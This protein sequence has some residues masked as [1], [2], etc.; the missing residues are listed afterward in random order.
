MN[1][2][3]IITAT[4]GRFEVFD[5]VSSLSKL[6]VLRYFY[7][8][9]PKFILKKYNI[10]S[11]R[12]TSF[13][14]IELFA[15]LIDILVR[16]NLKFQYFDFI[17]SLIFE[18]FVIKDIK[19]K[20]FNI[21]IGH[22]GYC[23]NIFKFLENNKDI[24]KILYVA[25]SHIDEKTKLVGLK[26]N[27]IISNSYYHKFKNEYQI[28]DLIICQS[29]HV[30]DGFKK[31][32]FKN[33]A[34]NVSGVNSDNFFYTDL[35]L[36]NDED[37]NIIFVGSIT[38]RKGIRR[39][40]KLFNQIMIDNKKLF[41]IG[42]KTNEI[43]LKKI[44]TDNIIY[45][46]PKANNALYKY[47]SSADLLFLFSKEEGFS[48]VLG[49]S[50]SCGTP[51][52]ASNKSGAQHFIDKKERGYVFNKFNKKEIINEIYNLFKIRKKIR[53]NKSYLSKEFK[54]KHT[55]ME[56][57]KKLVLIIEKFHQSKM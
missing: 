8:S 24:S 25:S 38:E 13:L 23:E 22:S 18:K 49:Q 14:V 26:Q 35:N 46:G 10:P 32:G 43:D 4:R 31:R 3:K 53:D 57:A 2:T 27:K 6:K 7:S 33:V 56:N 28:A 34:Y 51:V 30:Y 36:F 45:L 29:S 1:D 40:V 42:Q 15:R 20:E 47:Y 5:I 50:L 16:K 44:I 19:K 41:L 9:Y 48:M 52:I 17:I 21:F 55:W 11:N 12:S 39:M 37:Y 54:R